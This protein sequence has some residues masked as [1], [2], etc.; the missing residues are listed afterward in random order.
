MPHGW[1]RRLPSEPSGLRRSC[2]LAQWKRWAM[3]AIVCAARAAVGGPCARP[4]ATARTSPGAATSHAN[5]YSPSLWS[6]HA[7]PQQPE[8]ARQAVC[9]R[10]LKGWL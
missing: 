3:V 10:V 7:R 9:T 2:A 4:I 8:H 6:V 5:T 1:P